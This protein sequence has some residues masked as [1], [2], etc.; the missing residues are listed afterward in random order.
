ML[1]EM[2]AQHQNNDTFLSHVIALTD[3]PEENVSDGATRIVKLHIDDGGSLSTQQTTALI[4]RFSNFT[5][6]AAQLHIC[7]IASRLNFS[8]SQAAV[9]A[10]SLAPLISHQRP[11]LRAWALD[12]LCA[13]A[14]VNSRFNE[15]AL[16][17]LTAAEN[18]KAASVRARAKNIPRSSLNANS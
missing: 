10:S 16:E 14:R 1:S 5:S 12:A 8:S 18:D 4:Q 7:Q 15:Q 6:W 2:A 3:A 11:F 13:V 9:L 17:A